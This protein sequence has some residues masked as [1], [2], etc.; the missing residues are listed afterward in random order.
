[1]APPA[2]SPKR[3]VLLV[4]DEESLV[5]SLSSRLGKC[6]PQYDVLTAN[7]GE[8]ALAELSREPVELLVVDVRMPGMSGIDLV[9]A[10]RS[11]TPDLPVIVMT[12]FKTVDV[13]RIEGGTSTNFLE[14][15]FEF[16]VFLELVD[17]SLGRN[18]GFSGAISVQSLPELVQLY[19]LSNTSGKLAVRHGSAIGQLWFDRGMIVHATAGELAGEDGFFEILSW[20]AG[21][22]SMAAFEPPLSRSIVADWQGLLLESCR[23]LDEGQRGGRADRGWTESPPSWPPDSF[24]EYEPRSAVSQT[25]AVHLTLDDYPAE[26]ST[27]NIKDSL[28]KLNEIDGF[29]GAALVDSESGMMLGHEGG[30]G[31]DL[32]VAAAG[33]TEVVRAKRKTMAS[34]NLKDG[35]EDILITLGRQYHLIRPLRARNAVFFYVALDRQ[36]ANLAMA[37]I[38]LADVEKELAL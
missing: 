24:S 21:E 30:G 20:P 17:R 34:L 1:M 6:R 12:A 11:L 14:K 7:D 13:S 15:P 28:A 27:M 19:V 9:L 23:R 16:D 36:R 18:R 32:E 3:R 35:I 31:L 4:D 22:F 10:A 26:T 29:V 37:R 5:W 2:Q 33:N 8:T 25:S 38:A